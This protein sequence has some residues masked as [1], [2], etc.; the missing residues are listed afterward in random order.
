MMFTIG[1]ASGIMTMLI[2][3]GAIGWYLGKHP[4]VLVR[5]IMR[6]K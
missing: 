6:H 1:Y 2:V 3:S 4:R 5:R